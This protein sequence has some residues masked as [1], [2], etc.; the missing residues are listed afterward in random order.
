MASAPAALTSSSVPEASLYLQDVN[1]L[2]DTQAWG[3]DSDIICGMDYTSTMLDQLLTHHT[4][5]ARKSWRSDVYLHYNISVE[6]QYSNA[7]E[8]FMRYV[9]TCKRDPAHHAPQYR[10]RQDTSSGTNNL[11]RKATAC[12]LRFRSSQ[13]AKALSKGTQDF[14]PAR[15]RALLALW[16][17]RNHRPFELVHDEL[18]GM[19]VEELRPGTSLPDRTTLSRDVRALYQHNVERIREYFQVYAPNS[20]TLYIIY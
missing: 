18:F 17:A 14:S 3:I 11:L 15:L 9:F 8:P 12:D 16:S 1:K 4:A 6:R 7:G 20:T 2:S 5:A 10:R 19:I 13:D